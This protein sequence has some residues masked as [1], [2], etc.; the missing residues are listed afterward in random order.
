MRHFGFSWRRRLLAAAVLTVVI[1]LTVVAGAFADAGN[2]ITGTMHISTQD[3]GSTVT[4]YV[5]GQWNWLSHT[6]DCNVDRAATGVGIAWQ[7]LNGTGTTRGNSETQRV[8]ITGSPTGGTFKLKFGGQTTAA[9]PFNATAAQLDSFLE[10]LSSIGPGNVT[11]SGGPGPGTPFDVTFTGSLAK[12]DVSAMTLANK[13]FTGGSAPN[14]AITTTTN[15]AAPVF[16]GYLLSSGGIS[17]YIGTSTATTGAA[18]NLQDQM[19]HPVDRGNV[20]E[21]YT[22]GGTDYPAGQAFFDPSPP[23]VTA[24]STWRG[25]CGREPLTATA[26]KSAAH[27]DHTGLSC[28]TGDTSCAGHPW[29]SWGYEKNGGKGYSHTYLKTLPDGTSGL[30]DRICVNFYDVHG[31]SNP[32]AVPKSGDITVNGNNDNSISTNDFS[33]TDGNYCKVFSAPALTLAKSVVGSTTYDHV[34]QQVS[35]SYLVTN[36]GTTTFTGPITV[37]DTKI[38]GGATCP[39]GGLI[40]GA[41]TTCTATYTTT[42]TDLDSGSVTNV[43]Q[44]HANGTDSN[45]DTKTVTA[46][47]SPA[48]SL[49]KDAS[50]TT[51]SATSDTI[52]YTYTV[53][54]TGNVTLAGPFQIVDD[55]QGTILSCGSG[56]LGP[57]ATTTCTSTHTISQADLDAG[58]ITNK[59]TASTTYNLQTVTSNQAQATVN[60]VA[61]SPARPST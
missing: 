57:Q 7:D 17:A 49:T 1:S 55:K 30:P 19:V 22:L 11:V 29:G 16:N 3:N 58:S 5:R 54:N 53:K 33:I 27:P 23:N 32:S 31:A 38:P 56:P 8:A 4:V 41:S 45:T 35:Y 10:A 34:G 52:T 50:P 9:I 47:Q 15:G 40:P 61:S 42:Q 43:A 37:T 39:A 14:V 44:A 21:G 28:S 60:A 6:S 48:L 2:P 12:Q 18:V 25:G 46:V 24:T 59:A 20:P 13:S 51:Y 26:E 36:S